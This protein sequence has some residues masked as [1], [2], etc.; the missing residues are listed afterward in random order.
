M[1]IV[2]VFEEKEEDGFYFNWKMALN[3][4]I[5]HPICDL[6]PQN[7]RTVTSLYTEL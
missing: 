5:F 2:R 7:E 1:L 6:L 3:V 4:P